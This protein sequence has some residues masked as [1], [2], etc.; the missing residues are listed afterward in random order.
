MVR[1]GE[2]YEAV[3]VV[4]E[5]FDRNASFL[6]GAKIDNEEM[7]TRNETWRNIKIS[8]PIYTSNV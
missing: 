2:A 3:F 7:I 1:S 4:K 6:Y 8:S 5:G